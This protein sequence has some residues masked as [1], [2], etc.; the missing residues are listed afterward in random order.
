[1]L[2]QPNCWLHLFCLNPAGGYERPKLKANWLEQHVCWLHCCRYLP[3][4]LSSQL[5]RVEQI[6]SASRGLWGEK[7]HSNLCIYIVAL[8]CL[9][10]PFQ[11]R[12]LCQNQHLESL[13]SSCLRHL[14]GNY[15]RVLATFLWR[16]RKWCP[17][18]SGFLAL[19]IVALSLVLWTDILIQSRITQPHATLI[20][21]PRS[22]SKFWS[23]FDSQRTLLVPVQQLLIVSNWWQL[24]F[25]QRLSSFS[26]F[27]K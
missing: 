1:M 22:R 9:K 24:A 4:L 23:R 26:L 3:S 12:T 15:L 14:V 17:S 16:S 25:L 27:I 18:R 5:S 8:L 21:N 11:V 20:I 2:Q 19:H 6:F 13:K 7:T 10:G